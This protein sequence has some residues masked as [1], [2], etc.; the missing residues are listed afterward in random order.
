MTTGTKHPRLRDN[1]D[2]AN[3]GEETADL[4][5]PHF[6]GTDSVKHL[7][8]QIQVNWTHAFWHFF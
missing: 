4:L 8:W 1:N 2:G 7:L 3:V 5:T 6:M